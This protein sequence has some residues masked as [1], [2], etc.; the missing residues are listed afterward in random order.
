MVLA[1]Q[2]STDLA[3]RDEILPQVC[4]TFFVRFWKDDSESGGNFENILTQFLLKA[5]RHVVELY[6]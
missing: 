3:A 1:K 4:E 2:S 6:K 5:A